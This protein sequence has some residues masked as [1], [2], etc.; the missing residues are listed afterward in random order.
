M[1]KTLWLSKKLLPYWVGPKHY[2]M[3]SK[4]Q[5]STSRCNNAQLKS[6]FR[7]LLKGTIHKLPYMYSL[8]ELLIRLISCDI[9]CRKLRCYYY[10]GVISLKY[11]SLHEQ[12]SKCTPVGVLVM[13]S[14]WSI[15]PGNILLP[16][17]AIQFLLLSEDVSVL[18]QPQSKSLPND[19]SIIHIQKQEF[20]TYYSLPAIMHNGNINHH[21]DLSFNNL[22]VGYFGISI[23]HAII[24]IHSCH[25]EIHTSWKYISNIKNILSTQLRCRQCALCLDDWRCPRLQTN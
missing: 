8:N 11:I 15:W 14:W 21:N 17:A 4:N 20:L 2:K 25:H 16:T 5:M 10:K 12:A 7:Q 18:W 24:S 1:H 23:E 3:L 22:V 6:E 13:F 9:H 19:V